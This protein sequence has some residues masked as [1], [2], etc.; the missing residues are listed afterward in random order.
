MQL[1]P[2]NA[3]PVRVRIEVTLDTPIRTDSTAAMEVQGV[4]G[5]ALIAIS[6]GS[7]RAPLLRD[8]DTG[9]VPVIASSRS[10][11]QTLSDEGPQIIERLSLVAEQLTQVLG[12]E[13]QGRVAAILDNVERSSGNL[14]RALDDV[15]TATD[16]IAQ[17]ATG[18]AA[19]GAQMDG[20]SRSAGVTLDRFADAASRAETTLAAAT[21]NCLSVR[22]GEFEPAD[23][24]RFR[25]L[26]QIE[27]QIL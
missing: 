10:A 26:I 14:D 6:A 19:F 23:R 22:C 13:N 2:G 15:A 16:A 12:P 1:A 5:V 18:I 27:T 11:L 7:A 17:A 20:L 9:A 8:A 4:T 25:G 21:A 24:A 3:L